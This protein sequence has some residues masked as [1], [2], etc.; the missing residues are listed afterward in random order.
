M[1]PFPHR[2]EVGA[3]AVPEG[4]VQLDSAGIPA[5]RTAP[6]AEFDG[7]GDAWSPETLL[8]GAVADCFV[9]SFR[10]VAGASKVP[11]TALDVRVQGELDRVDKVTQ[12]TAMH[13]HARL[14]VPE[15][16]PADRA[17]RLLQRAEQVC[18]I[19]N[20]LKATVHLTAEV[21]VG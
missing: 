7:P 15:G 16:V 1:H 20:S 4:H 21:V 12:F 19:S 18:L 11:W 17:E 2:Y 9:F 10:A 5:L 14:Q 6:P 13:V 8:V 3:H